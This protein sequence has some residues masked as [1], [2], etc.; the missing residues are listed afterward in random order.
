M[1]RKALI[2]AGAAG[3]PEVANGVL[4]RFGFGP[5]E[6]ALGITE[7]SALMRND[8]YDLI[9]VPLQDVSAV[10]LAA[11]EREA[12]KSQQ[13]FLIGTAAKSDPELI[14]RAMRSGVHEFLVFPPDPTD[15]AG[16][17]DRLMRRTAGERKVGTSVAVYSA[18]GGLGTTSVAVNLAF[19]LAAGRPDGRI[20][21]ADMVTSGG[22]VRVMLNLH[23]AYD[24]GDVVK[25]ADRLDAGLLDSL[26]TACKG[27]VW[28]LPTSDDPETIEVL[29]GPTATIVI[30]HLRSQFGCTVVDCD[31]HM[32]EHTLAALDTADRV[33]LVT[34]LNVAALRS[35]QRTLALCER[36]GYSKEKVEVVV[37]RHD[38]ADVVSLADAAQVLR[39]P[40]FF[41]L[42]NDYQ[43]SSAALTKGVPI[44]QQAPA[45][46][47]AQAY[48]LLA[49]KLD[50]RDDASTNGNGRGGRLG[51]MF[52]FG[53]K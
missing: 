47:L 21:L 36:L 46:P 41:K 30:D 29:D 45:T 38:Q 48:Q 51:R 50:G 7:A 53:R 26:L 18:K 33:L 1:Q 37:N 19:A 31:H 9:V 15:F 5:A 52:S 17:V 16:A 6:S 20:A 27:G 32:G 4:Q 23:P 49:A 39:K 43:S 28:V 35:T 40:I 34:Q 11:L 10:E 2:V 8:R 22:D 14:V 24:I 13:T 42:P 25:K 44:Q 12:R 3:P